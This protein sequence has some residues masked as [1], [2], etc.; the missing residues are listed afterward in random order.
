VFLLAAEKLYVDPADCVVIED[1]IAGVS[2]ARRA[3]MKCLAVT[4]SHS[5]SELKQADLVENTLDK[6][7]IRELKGLFK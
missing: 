5:A 6:V 1:A 7:S 4:N 2:A 3:G